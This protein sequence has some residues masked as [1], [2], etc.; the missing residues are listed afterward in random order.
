MMGNTLILDIGKTNIKVHVLDD[1][2]ES[3]HESVK[4]NTVVNEGIYP[5]FDVDAIWDW[6]CAAVS[7]V[8]K[9]LTVS[10]IS[11]T[12]HGATAALIDRNR[13]GNALVL[14]V[15]DYEHSGPDSVSAGYAEVRPDFSETR[16]PNLSAGLNLG[17][18]LFWQQQSAPDS[19]AAATDVLL[20]PQYWVWRMT[21]VRC[22]EVTSL[23]C[24]TDLWSPDQ[25]D[26]S[27][28]VDRMGWRELFPGMEPANR[29]VGKTTPEFNR[30]A[31]LTTAC[32]VTAGIHD[33]NASYLRY[34]Q[35]SDGKP[36]A[37]VST[38]TWAITMVSGTGAAQLDE[39]R[40]MLMNVDYRGEPVPCARF[41]A[42]REYES[43]CNKMGS[44]P[45]EP[46]SPRDIENIFA[47]GVF[48]LPQFCD[49]SG[50]F[51]GSPGVIQPSTHRI[52]GAALASLY[53]ALMLDLELDLLN[54]EGDVFLEGAFLKNPLL[55]QLL[56]ALRPQ[57]RVIPS[58]DSTGTVKGA[59]ALARS[60][61][62]TGVE[63]QRCEPLQL[64]GLEDYRTQW[65]AQCRAIDR[66]LG[67]DSERVPLTST[68]TR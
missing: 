18:Q 32:P 16:S 38:G 42:G 27:S 28:L 33:S 47:D 67:R 19:F 63:P 31:G 10:A 60:A 43:I 39:A 51:A 11:V 65:R 25:G 30:K 3:I 57:D 41:M 68:S 64:E 2:L 53:C 17:R 1:N 13:S 46:F 37:V 7:E 24:H 40:D 55:C 52:N 61:P 35:S 21:G 49:T 6:F 54:A 14:P 9:T 5:H 20:Y 23:G 58:T 36:F 12:T 15:L 50:P 34:V 66:A 48:A 4:P 59:A 29:L 56:A 26:Y 8:T 62:V 44:F 22:T 45:E